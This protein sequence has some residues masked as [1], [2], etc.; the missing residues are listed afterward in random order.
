MRDEKTRARSGPV[1]DARL[2]VSEDAQKRTQG[3]ACFEFHQLLAIRSPAPERRE[4]IE[5]E[6]L[7]GQRLV[8]VV[9]GLERFQTDPNARCF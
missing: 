6:Y 9:A 3:N 5:Y 2:D 7:D 1:S 4:G 8:I